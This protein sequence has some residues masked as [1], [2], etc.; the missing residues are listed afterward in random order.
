MFNYY[1]YARTSSLGQKPNPEKEK[2]RIELK[3]SKCNHNLSV[4]LEINEQR[5][6]KYKERVANYVKEVRYCDII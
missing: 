1:R 5:I 6:V 2:Q 3:N 4:G